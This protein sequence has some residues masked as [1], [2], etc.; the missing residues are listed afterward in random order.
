VRRGRTVDI[1]NWDADTYAR[2]ARRVKKMT[3]QALLDW[4]DM[5]G[6]GMEKGFRDFAAEEKP[7]IALC[8]LDEI[9]LALVS[10]WALNEEL[11]L[12]HQP[13]DG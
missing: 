3:D 7:E 4:T 2:A 6:S 8:S 13:L 1:P 11:K 10:L 5:A 12:R 9:S